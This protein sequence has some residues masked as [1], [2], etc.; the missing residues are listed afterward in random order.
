V[1]L[2]EKAPDGTE[3]AH[4]VH[5]WCYLGSARA[6]ADVWSLLEQSPARPAFDVDTY[7]ILVRALAKRQVRVRPLPRRPGQVAA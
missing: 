3:Q 1:A 6:E 7:K 2:V 5:N 4:V